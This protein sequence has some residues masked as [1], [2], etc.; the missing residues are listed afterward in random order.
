MARTICQPELVI[1]LLSGPPAVGKTT[2]G[3]HL[4]ERCRVPYLNRDDFKEHV[5][6]LAQTPETIARRYDASQDVWFEAVIAV[7]RAGRSLLAD[8][9]ASSAHDWEVLPRRFGELG[10][11][12]VEVR[13]TAPRETLIDRFRCRSNPPYAGH[14][15]HAVDEAIDLHQRRGRLVPGSVELVYDTA[16]DGFSVGL[17]ESDLQA[18][19]LVP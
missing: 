14:L 18:R 5:Y 19:G 9:V 11:E 10:Q 1:V 13:L 3:R 7:A 17:V 6:P 2:V 8:P 12:I 4:S 15:V 16:S